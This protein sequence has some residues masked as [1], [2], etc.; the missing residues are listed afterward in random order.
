MY[1]QPQ[2]QAPQIASFNPQTSDLLTPPSSCPSL[3]PSPSPYARSV[4]S[5]DSDFCDPRNL[6]VGSVN[7]TLAPE[8]SALPTLCAGEDEDQKFVLR[9]ATR[10]VSPSSSFDFNSQLCGSGASSNVPSFDDL[11]D[12]DS[13]DDFVNGLV[14]LGDCGPAQGNRSRAS[15]DAVSFGQSDGAEA[16]NALAADSLLTPPDSCGE[17]DGHKDKRRKKSKDSAGSTATSKSTMGPTADSQSGSTQQQT[18]DNQSSTSPAATEV[19]NASES[20]SASENTTATPIPAPTSRRGRKQSLTEDPSKTFVCDI[21]HRRFRRQ[22]HLKRHYRSLHTQE[23]PFECNE[24]GKKFS[25]SD[26]LAQ[27]ARTHGSGAIVMNLID[28]PDTMAAAAG[29]P[30]AYPAP[31]MMATPAPGLVGGEDYRTLGKVLFQIA[32]E[33]P[34]SSS[35]ELSSDE[36]GSDHGK[37]KRKRAE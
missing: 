19:K 24:C 7:S 18:A 12:L 32:A 16:A 23:K 28:D 3:S 8:F 20:N 2:A 27:H 29:M 9:G 37:K 36:G 13:E 17:S 30:P 14:D 22:E 1:L 11:S 15:S 10:S 5:D 21:C 34:G 26:N 35:S 25:R 6:T 4:S 31:S 33:V